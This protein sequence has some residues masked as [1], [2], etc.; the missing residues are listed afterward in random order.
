[1][2][3]YTLEEIAERVAPVAAEYRLPAVYLFGSYARGEADEESDVDLLVDLTGTQVKGLFSMT[4]P[5]S[6]GGL[7][8]DL[9]AALG[10]RIDLLTVGAL[11]K[12]EDKFGRDRF[13]DAILKERALI[14]GTREDIAW[15]N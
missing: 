13:R 6:L 2:A 12:P 1:M 14:Y 5:W 3:V 8:S 11:E 10:K 4:S 9:E 7:Y 15:R